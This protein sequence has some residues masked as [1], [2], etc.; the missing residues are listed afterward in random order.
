MET[1]QLSSIPETMLITLWAKATETIQYGGLIHDEVAKDIIGNID[2]DFS[3][4]KHGKLSQIGSCVRAALIDNETRAFLAK[5]PDGV[6][7]QLGAGL[8]GRYQRL[9]S[10]KLTHWFDLDLKE[11]IDIR[12]RLIPESERNTYLDLSMFD[13]QWIDRVKSY[14]KSVLILVEG[15]LMYFEPAIVREFFKTVCDRF[16]EAMLVFD[17]LAP[18]ALRHADKHDT[19]KKMSGNVSFLWSEMDTLVMEAWHDKLHVGKEYYMS[20]HDQGRFPLIL[21][22][23]FLIPYFYKRLNQR[24]VR[25]DIR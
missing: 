22:L 25:I 1:K 3:K 18:F 15:V 19:V 7:I 11:V 6:V 14:G 4:F 5:Y 21:R 23:M 8:D 13:Y 10:P 12:R 2:Y 9:G 16:E 24:I 17:M 20:D